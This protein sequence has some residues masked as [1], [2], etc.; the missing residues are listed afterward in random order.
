MTNTIDAT[1]IALQQ[2]GLRTI[3]SARALIYLSGR[4]ET[5][6]TELSVHLGISHAA[7]TDLIDRLASRGLITRDRTEEDR[8]LVLANITPAGRQLINPLAR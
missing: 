8:R 2:R 1:L 4:R 7:T 5:P 3:P 6:A